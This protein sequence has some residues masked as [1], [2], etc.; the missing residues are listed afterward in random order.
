[1]SGNRNIILAEAQKSGASYEEI[2]KKL[3]NANEISVAKK[4]DEKKKK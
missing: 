3:L 2:A 4:S 1:M